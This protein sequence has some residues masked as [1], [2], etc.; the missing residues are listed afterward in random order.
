[1]NEIEIR[2][3]LELLH[4]ADDALIEV[5]IM[6]KNKTYSGYFKNKELLVE[7]LKKTNTQSNVY[8]TL[9]TIN[10]ACYSRKQ[11]DNIEISSTT[12]TDANIINRN[13]LFIDIDAKRPSDVSS[14]ESELK[15]SVSLAR[16]IF[17]YMR[18]FGFYEPIVCMSGNGTYLLYRINIPNTPENTEL[19][20]TCLQSLDMLFSNENADIDVSV[21]NPSRIAKIIGTIARKG[22]NTEDRPHRL[23]KILSVPQEVK[24]NEKPLLEKLAGLIPQ[25]EKPTYENNYGR[26]EFDIDN[27]ISEFNIPIKKT[28]TFKDGKKYLLESCPF[29]GHSS[30]DSAIFKLNNG[31]LG[32]KCFHNSCSNKTWKEFREFYQPESQRRQNYYSGDIRFMNNRTYQNKPIE[33]KQ[34]EEQTEEKGHVWLQ[35]GDIKYE[36]RADIITMPTGIIQ[37]DQKIIGL[38]RGETTV[39]SGLN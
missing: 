28:Q 26:S 39:V 12:T 21:F 36:S 2:R 32:F 30:P 23:S 7:K 16:D 29:C 11:K 38:N 6:D 25:K 34:P 3:F 4:P 13:W 8:F 10:D 20:K 19:I 31:S 17:K 1:M 33:K 35:M 9:N 15:S 27:F 37:L 24:I 22:S 18:N 5:R 14:N